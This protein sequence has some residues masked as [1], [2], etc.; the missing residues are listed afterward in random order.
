MKFN[1]FIF[2]LYD[3]FVIIAKLLKLWRTLPT[4]LV[5]SGWKRGALPMIKKLYSLVE[6]IKLSQ[7][8]S[9]T[10]FSSAHN[11]ERDAASFLT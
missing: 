11:K 4:S 10:Q 6:L 2:D 8:V 5:T 7:H 3:F 9:A 1:I